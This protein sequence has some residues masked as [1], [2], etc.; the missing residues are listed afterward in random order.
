MLDSNDPMQA[1]SGSLRQEVQKSSNSTKRVNYAA[2]M[3]K[4]GLFAEEEKKE[5][6]EQD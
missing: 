4:T 3:I 5:T 1:T 2:G 6:V